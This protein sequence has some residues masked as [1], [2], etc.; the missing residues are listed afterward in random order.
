MN[1]P[2]NLERTSMNGT[3]PALAS[4]QLMT[5]KEVVELLRISR[6]TL[7]EQIRT[8]GSTF[9]RPIIVAGNCTRFR[10]A[11]VKSYVAA[12]TLPEPVAA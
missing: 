7:Y 1:R 6:A 2:A 5:V 11:D 10:V 3:P 9:P 8:P 4:D 12:R